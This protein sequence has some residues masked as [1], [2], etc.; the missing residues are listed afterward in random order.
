MDAATQTLDDAE[1]EREWTIPPDESAK[2]GNGA[3]DDQAVNGSFL[4]QFEQEFQDIG[5]MME[6]AEATGPQDALPE[7]SK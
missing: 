2:N 3:A 7:N 5:E 4:E 6:D 1:I